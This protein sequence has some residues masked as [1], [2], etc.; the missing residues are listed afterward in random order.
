MVGG[1]TVSTVIF[2]FTEG[3]LVGRV[4]T[5]RVLCSIVRSGGRGDLVLIRK[6]VQA[7]T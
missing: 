3:L 6:R 4:S 5:V 7:T 2:K 1:E